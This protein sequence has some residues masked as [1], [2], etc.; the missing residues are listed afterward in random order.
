MRLKATSIKDYRVSKGVISNT[1]SPVW[2][3]VCMDDT[4]FFPLLQPEDEVVEVERKLS[5]FELAFQLEGK[6]DSP[7]EK[8]VS[9]KSEVVVDEDL[10]HGFFKEEVKDEFFQPNASVAGLGV[11]LKYSKQHM[12]RLTALK[13]PV[14]V[15]CDLKS[16]GFDE[17]QT[18]L[19]EEV[20]NL[21]KMF[22]VLH[23]SLPFIEQL[24]L[25]DLLKEYSYKNVRLIGDNVVKLDGSNFSGLFPV[26][27]VRHFS[28]EF[29]YKN[30]VHSTTQVKLIQ[31]TCSATDLSEL[32]YASAIKGISPKKV[33]PKSEKAPKEVKSKVEKPKKVAVAKKPVKKKLDRKSL[34]G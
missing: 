31:K 11:S 30:N 18:F 14:F 5:M 1:K 25:H 16:K 23:I 24:A 21:T 7:S 27:L 10:S 33:K 12:E 9:E 22:Y 34:F 3:F 26:E 15:Y 20:N 6:I 13:V 29:N 8:T 4:P 28:L 2:Q 19:K 17:V 32:D